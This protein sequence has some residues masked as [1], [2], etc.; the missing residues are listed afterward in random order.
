[1]PDQR[2]MTACTLTALILSGCA[3]MSRV[4]SAAQSDRAQ[5]LAL[6][7][8]CLNS[9]ESY[10]FTYTRRQIVELSF[11]VPEVVDQLYGHCS[12]VVRVVLAQRSW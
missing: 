9:P 1:M 7:R 12:D 8:A 4:G 5:R 3:P 11:H 2:L 10:G 6:M